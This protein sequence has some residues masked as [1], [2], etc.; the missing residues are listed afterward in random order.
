MGI[1][2]DRLV[3][4]YLSKVGDLA[5]QRQL[6][7][8]ERMRLVTELRG[9]IERS[10]GGGGGGDSPAAVRRILS[11]LGSPDDV[12]TAA[13]GTAPAPPRAE[14]EPER[15]S[16]RTSERFGWGGAGRDAAGKSAAQDGD[17]PARKRSPLPRGLRRRMPGPRSPQA[18]TEAGGGSGSGKSVA[19]ELPVYEAVPL[20]GPSPPHLAGSDELG[21]PGSQPDWWRFDAEP[22]GGPGMVPGF[23]GGVEIPEILKPPPVRPFE[24]K[25]EAAVEPAPGGAP[26]APAAEPAAPPARAGRRGLLR[27]RRAAGAAAATGRARRWTNPLLLLAAALLIAGAAASNWIVLGVGWVIAYAS[28]RLTAAETKW[29]VVILPGLAAAGGVI[30]LWGRQNGRWGEP[31]A[32]GHMNVAVDGTWPWVVRA[33]A[34]ASALFLIWRSQRGR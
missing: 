20:D 9:E 19:P 21:P 3:L 27:S 23:T 34:L 12:V 16:E 15:T 31:I 32:Q 24:A 29:A 30:W 33:A 4:D 2:S 6:P 1:E 22:L 7:S 11:R 25:G 18:D 5:Q 26:G 28:R 8:S 17:G 13:G 14:P 10:R